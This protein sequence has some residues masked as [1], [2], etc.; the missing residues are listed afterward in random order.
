MSDQMSLI[1]PMGSYTYDVF[2]Q[3][4]RITFVP[5]VLWNKRRKN[6]HR[7]VGP[8]ATLVS[9]QHAQDHYELTQA[10]RIC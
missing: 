5:S 1:T 3:L 6:E 9:N 8:V 7:I 10:D 4:T 2:D